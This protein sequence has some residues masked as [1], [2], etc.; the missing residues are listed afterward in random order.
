MTTEGDR[1]LERF[2]QRV[3]DWL[4]SSLKLRPEILLEFGASQFATKRTV[5]LLFFEDEKFEPLSQ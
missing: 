1:H 2:W 5:R 3:P 4:N